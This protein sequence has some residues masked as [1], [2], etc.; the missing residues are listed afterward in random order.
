MS[1][2]TMLPPSLSINRNGKIVLSV[3]QFCVYNYEL[4]DTNSFNVNHYNG[5]TVYRSLLHKEFRGLSIEKVSQIASTTWK[6]ADKEFRLFFGNY[7]NQINSA[8]RNISPR[9]KLFE[10]NPKRK[11][12]PCNQQIKYLFVER[13]EY[14]RHEYEKAVE[15]FEFVSF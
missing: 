5:F 13:E 1:T 3:A 7:A 15:E 6:I 2:F 9:F 10:M 8:E 11:W 4:P 14:M 12:K